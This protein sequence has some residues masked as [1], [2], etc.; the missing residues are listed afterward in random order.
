[1]PGDVVFVDDSPA[2]VAEVEASFPEMECVVFPKSNCR[3]VWQL[4]KHLR[5]RF[6]K[7][8]VTA[9]DELRLSSIRRTSDLA[10]SLQARGNAA[11]N[12]F[13]GAEA[14]IQFS[15][16]PDARDNRAFELINKSNQ[17]NL[18]GRRF[19]EPEWQNF[20]GDPATFILTASYEDKYS[21]LG[22]IAVLAGKRSGSALYVNSWVM[23]CRAFSR[24]IEHQC[25][26]YLFEKIGID[27]ITFDFKITPRN[28][29]IQ[30]FFTELLGELPASAF[31]I[32]K[33]T[34]DARTPA[35]FHR[36]VDVTNA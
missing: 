20:I 26:K 36:V 5:H 21:P 12:F 15:L 29:P 8:V 11:T 16:I 7:G 1:M 3:A 24:C 13:R 35:L 32:Q 10:G 17:F 28:A 34:F 31:A 33:S 25:L 9:E 2:E 19:S 27:Q 30:N 4:I 18:N 23:S 14:T 6:G 22:K